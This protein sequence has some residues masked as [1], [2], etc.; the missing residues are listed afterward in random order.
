MS[1]SVFGI[2]TFYFIKSKKE[3]VYTVFHGLTPNHQDIFIATGKKLNHYIKGGL[4]NEIEGFKKTTHK[5]S[6]LREW[7]GPS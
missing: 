7:H 3:H 6:V 4:Q 1:T 5:L 2:N